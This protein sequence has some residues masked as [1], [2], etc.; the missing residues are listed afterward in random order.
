MTPVWD[1]FVTDRDRE[2][3]DVAGYGLSDGIEGDRAAIVVIDMTEAFVGDR[4]E[5]LRRSIERFPNSCGEEGWRLALRLAGTLDAA[6]DAAVPVYYSVKDVAHGDIAGTAWGRTRSGPPGPD[7]AY[8]TIVGPIVPHVRDTVIR[9]TKPS[10]FFSTP[11]LQYLLRDR[12]DVVVCVGATTSGCVRATAVDAF[13]HG[14]RV[15]VPGDGV[16]DRG[17]ASHA[18]GLFDLATKY[19]SVPTL[20]HVETWLRARP[21]VLRDE[22]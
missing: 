11:L 17:E 3:F 13:S 21:A 15:V 5:P 19:A 14:F 7:E 12:V 9:K 18:V 2:I 10:A 16:V 22:A 8:T 6:R 1:R 4:P 20:E